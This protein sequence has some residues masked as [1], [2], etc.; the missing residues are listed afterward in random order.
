MLAPILHYLTK[1]YPGT[2]LGD[3]A[4]GARAIVAALTSADPPMRLVLG[5]D[6][7]AAVRAKIEQVKADLAAWETLTLSTGFDK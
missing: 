2:E 3:P 4:K 5:E 6:A 1:I 7:L